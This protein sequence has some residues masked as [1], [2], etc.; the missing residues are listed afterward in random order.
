[1]GWLIDIILAIVLFVL[2][3][4]ELV[5]IFLDEKGIRLGDKWAGTMVIED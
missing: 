1:L 3:V 4:I 2:I 5:K